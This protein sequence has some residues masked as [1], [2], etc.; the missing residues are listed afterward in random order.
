MFPL[1]PPP[2]MEDTVDPRAKKTNLLRRIAQLQAEIGEKAG[3]EDNFRLAVESAITLSGLSPTP[4]HRTTSHSLRK[5][6]PGSASSPPKPNSIA[7][8]RR[9]RFSSALPKRRRGS[10]ITTAPTRQPVNLTRST[11]SRVSGRPSAR[12]NVMKAI[13]D[14]QLKAKQLGS[15]KE[16]VLVAIELISPLPDE[17]AEAYFPLAELLLLQAKTGD[18]AGAL[19][20]VSAVS[21][22]AWKVSI[23][24]EIAASHAEAGRKDEAQKTLRL[25]L[26]ASRGA[27]NDALWSSMW[28]PTSG[29]LDPWLPVLRLW[30]MPRP[31]SAISTRQSKRLPG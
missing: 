30:L 20:N 5:R 4:W 25:A 21:S 9:S 26:D 24:T 23:L 8:R 22:S 2:G 12:V 16:T 19:H 6:S 17:D 10:A 18:L 29:L 31:A 3:S 27:P 7:H 28:K 13:A 11:T 14:A 15:A 1:E